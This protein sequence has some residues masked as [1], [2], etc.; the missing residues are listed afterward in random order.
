MTQT[1]PAKFPLARQGAG[2]AP[3][4]R[5]HSIRRTTTIES[6]WPDGFGKNA[7]M[8]G[9]ARDLMT[10]GDWDRPT[11][12]ATGGFEILASPNREILEIRSEPG[13]PRERELVGVRAGGASREALADAMGDVAGQPVYQLIDDFA[14]ASL[15]A[16]W[17]W[18]HWDPEWVQRMREQAFSAARRGPTVDV[19]TGF[20][21]GSSALEAIATRRSGGPDRTEVLPLP[22]PEDP[23]GWH[24]MGAP[25]SEPTLRRSRRIDIWREGDLLRVDAG[26]Q[27]SGNAPDGARVAVHE[28]RV[29]A[30]VEAETGLVRALQATP[31][32]LPFAECPGATLN[33]ARLIGQPVAEFRLRVIDALPGPAGCTHLNDVL[34]ALADVPHMAAQ[35][36]LEA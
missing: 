18:A 2:H 20:A 3:L 30:A 13:H 31:L 4:R 6:R 24:D 25:P 33:I 17:I 16:G 12:V 21:Q 19:C 14:G 22:N 10:P 34:R 36:P 1:A 15:V 35:M 26:F 32:I 7:V 29:E 28:Y 23:L 9:R 5:R 8:Q 27:D 11:T